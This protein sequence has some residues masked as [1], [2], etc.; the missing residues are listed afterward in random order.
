M[1]KWVKIAIGCLFISGFIYTANLYF[2]YKANSYLGIYG[3]ELNHYKN[4]FVLIVNNQNIDTLNVNIPS[5]FSKGFNFLWEE[6]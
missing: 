1:I 6:T 3:G 5:P 2:N 4:D